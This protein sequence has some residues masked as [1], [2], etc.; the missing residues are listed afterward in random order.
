MSKIYFIHGITGSRNNFIYLQ[1]HF[2]GSE[3]FDLIGFGEA[4]KPDA[5]YNKEFFVQYMETKIAEKAI[6][7]GHSMG[8]ILAKEYAIA[9]PEQVERL[10][11]VSYPIQKDKKALEQMVF[12]DGYTRVLLGNTRFSKIINVWDQATRFV[13][14]PGSYLFWRKYWL[15]VRD[16]Y[17][18]TPASL[19]RSVSNTIMRDDYRTLAQVKEKSVFIVGENDRNADQLLLKD[20]NPHIIPRMR[21]YF[22]GYE[23]QIAAI[24][25]QKLEQP[26]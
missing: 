22:F 9:H 4:P 8:A 5:S 18:H 3:S 7:V 14:V 26:V 6:L 17:R 12:R 16:Y 21:H 11:L 24:I 2:A 23:D 25:K 13:A 1:K 20:F 15:T 19:S 10:F